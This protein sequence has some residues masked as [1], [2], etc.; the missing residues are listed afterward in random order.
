MSASAPF[1][2]GFP[3]LPTAA[4]ACIMQYEPELQTKLLLL[5]SNDEQRY[6]E[7]AEAYYFAHKTR[8]DGLIQRAQQ[9]CPH[10]SVVREPDGDFGWE[11][12]CLLC[13]K[14]L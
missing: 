4:R 13:S 1:L 6:V 10:S 11:R 3:P 2:P 8:R 12:R 14:Y 9:S 7:R 5:R